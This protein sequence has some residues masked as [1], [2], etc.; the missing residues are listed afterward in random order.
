MKTK[1]LTML[2]TLIFAVATIAANS[3]SLW[4]RFEPKCP[5][6]LKK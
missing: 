5:E 4:N 1:L 6:R 3:P 2:Y